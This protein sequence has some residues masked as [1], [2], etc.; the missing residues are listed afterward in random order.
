MNR[1][2][3]LNYRVY[4]RHMGL[5]EGEFSAEERAGLIEVS[6]EAMA[7]NLAFHLPLTFRKL[8]E[9]GADEAALTFYSQLMHL[10]D[11]YQL[12]LDHPLTIRVSSRPTAEESVDL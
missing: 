2:A 3:I 7:N 8:V 4:N 11:T 9:A 12:G 5:K 6:A 1:V 10:N